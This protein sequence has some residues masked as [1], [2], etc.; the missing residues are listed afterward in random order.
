MIAAAGVVINDSLIVVNFINKAKD[1]GTNIIRATIDVNCRR[2][3]AIMITSITTFVGLIPVIF[4][5]SLQAKLIIPMAVSLSFG[6]L[7][8]TLV[9]L[10]LV[11]S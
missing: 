10:I 11:P 2:F 6:V 5:T 4:E 3:R 1:Q 8:S 7:F 9:T